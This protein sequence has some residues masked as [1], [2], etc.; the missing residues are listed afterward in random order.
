ML[1][2]HH[3]HIFSESARAAVSHAIG[4]ALPQF[5]SAELSQALDAGDVA[6]PVVLSVAYMHATAS[7]TAVENDWVAEQCRDDRMIPFCSVNAI[8]PYATDEVHRCLRQGV[9]HGLKLH[10][11]NSGVDLLDSEHRRL[12]VAVLQAA[13]GGGFPAVI[14]LRAS[15]S[16]TTEHV[17]AFVRHVAPVARDVPL[18]IAHL[19]GWGGYDPQTARGLAAL[20][21]LVD[22][23]FDLYF[24]V[25]AV[26][27]GQDRAA[28]DDLAADLDAVPAERLLFGTDWPDWT[29]RD[30]SQTLRTVGID[31]ARFA[32][33]AP[34]VP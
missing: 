4:R 11:A 8:A 6:K 21:N 1:V 2:D 28:V 20:A 13:A 9:F 15:R 17:E 12:L 7:A 27:R 32:S 34:W 23:G 10:L 24:D 3:V 25:S 19:G 29:A 18:Q 26:V 14:H 22:D 16:W 33:R 30:Y 31:L 5:A